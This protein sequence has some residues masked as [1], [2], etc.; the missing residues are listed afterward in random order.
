[1]NKQRKSNNRGRKAKNTYTTRSGQSIKLNRSLSEKRKA[2]KDAK[3]RSKAARLNGMPNSKIKRFF[4]RLHPKRLY[5]YWFSREGLVMS[6]RLMGIGFVAVFLVM[7][8]LFAYFRKDLPNLRDISGMNIG[9]SVQYYDRTGEVL[10]WEDFDAVKRVPIEGDNIPEH[11]KNATIALEDKDFYEHGGFDVRGITRAAWHNVSGSGDSLQGGSTITQQLVKLTQDWTEDRTYTRKMKELILAVEMERT[12]S[13][14]EILTAYLNTAP[15]GNIQYGIESAAQDYFHKS[16]ANLTLEEAAFLA[17]IPQSPSYYSPYGPNFNPEALTGRQHQVLNEM[18]KEKMISEDEA[19]AA[20][21]I[22]ILDKV[23][24]TAPKYENIKAP[25]FVLAAKSEME[26]KFGQETIQ[27]GGWKVTTT[28]DLDLQQIAEEEIEDGMVQ[29][30]RQGGNVAAFVAS[31]VETG[32]IVA[33]VG[34]SDFRNDQHGQINFARTRMSP[35]SSVKPYVYLAMMEHSN[36]VGAGS[37]LYDT[38]GPLEGYPCTNTNSRTGNCLGNY[39]SRYP[40]PMTIRYALGGSRNVPAAKAMLQTG[41]DETI[42]TADSLG[43]ESGY[44]CFLDEALT[45]EGPCYA[46][47]S[48]G[49]GA[50]LR[51]DEHVHSYG[52]LSRNGNLLPRSYI[53]NIEDASGGMLYEWEQESGNQVVRPDS[54]YIISDILADPDASYMFRKPHRYQGWKFSLKTGTTNDKKDGL[55]L[56]YST[57][58]SAGVWVGN[59]D[60]RVDMTGFMSA[61]TQPIWTNWMNRA[62]DGLEPIERPRPGGVKEE[63]AYVVRSNPGGA[64]RVP[65]R[66]TD[67]YPSWYR[68]RDIDRSRRTIDIVSE[69]LATDCTPERARQEVTESNANQFSSDDYVDNGANLEEEDDVHSCDDRMP[70]ISLNVNQLSDGRYDISANVR[71]GTHPI[72]SSRFQGKV[73]FRIGGNTIRSMQIDGAGN[74]PSFRYQPDFEG[75]RQLTAIIIDSVLYS[76]NS[77]PITISGGNDDDEEPE[78]DEEPDDEDPGGGGGQNPGNNINFPLDN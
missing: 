10:L 50:Y 13:K 16:A 14:D 8:G 19:Q 28:L 77:N 33:L 12:F 2:K 62:H 15:Y 70:S 48:F 21:E 27:R 65:S 11:I 18:V 37:V 34:G 76:S 74:T 52:T 40:G 7:V 56:G 64:A 31:D 61:M 24:P 73:E 30:R 6:M 9:G 59:H 75:N 45:Q 71:N 53:L 41:V 25:W 69:K 72:S 3:A 54:A 49:D 26:K 38:R 20:K 66:D 60:R 47:A 4:Y 17:A 5:R 43:L 1:M 39:D 35:G 67:L 42:E 78:P 44:K 57:K 51:L 58:Y 55:L 32:Q 36:N 23:N 46:A 68:S 22:D 29:V 63:K